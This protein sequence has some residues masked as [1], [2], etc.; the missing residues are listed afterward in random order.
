MIK[1]KE[2]MPEINFEGSGNLIPIGGGKDSAVSLEL[3]KD[4]D[5]DID[6]R[7]FKF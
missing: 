5:N 1:E 3:L 4:M 6:I 7:I 2:E